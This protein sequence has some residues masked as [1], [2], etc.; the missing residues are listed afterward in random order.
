MFVHTFIV[1]IADDE[2]V[3]ACTI[4]LLVLCV[5][6][7]YLPPGYRCELLCCVI[8][9]CTCWYSEVFTVATF[10]PEEQNL[11]RYSRLVL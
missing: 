11:K 3:S 7:G 4:R 5:C 8:Q 10:R 2:I 9:L 6:D 1:L